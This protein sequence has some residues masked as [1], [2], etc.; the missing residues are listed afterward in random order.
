MYLCTLKI[1]IKS[2]EKSEAEAI[3]GLVCDTQSPEDCSY[4]IT[5]ADFSDSCEAGTD[6]AVIIDRDLEQLRSYRRQGEERVVFLA[7]AGEIAQLDDT[8]LSATDDLWVFPDREI[9]AKMLKVYFSKLLNTLKDSFDNR[10]QDICFH[11]FI[12]SLPDLVW[13]KDNDG[14]HLIVNDTFCGVVEKN[15][16]Q[17]YKRHHN[18]IWGLPE[19][20]YEHGEGICR[21]SEEVVERERKTCQFDEQVTTKDGTRQLVTYK[22]P[23]I[24]TD[25]KI[26][27]TCG[28]GHD[29]TDL[30]NVSKELKFIIDCIPFG[31]AI[32]DSE[33]KVLS[34]NRFLRKYF[35]DTEESKGHLFQEWCDKLPKE[36]LGDNDCEEEYRIHLGKKEHILRFREEP[37]VDI[38]GGNLGTLHFIRDVTLQ[39]NYDQQNIKHANTDFLTGLNNRRSLFD[40]LTGLPENSKISII[41]ADLDRFKS[42][43]DT[44]G[45]AAGDEA[46]EITSRT[47]EECFE[48]GFIARLGGDEFL[49]ALVGEY[50]LPE[51]EK[52]TQTLLDTLLKKYSTKKEFHALSSS[53]GIAQERLA[54]CD[55][56]SIEN[57]IKRSDDALYTAKES[58]K[59]RYCVNK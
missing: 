48:D 45:H 8:T 53:A 22:S 33:D 16:Q 58:G 25:G 59:A 56:G 50:E 7:S 36:K 4:H 13:F 47:L 26:F 40:Y 12:D 15:K 23:L 41:M 14:A 28:M 20:D 3:A 55:I 27:G 54:V 44:Y 35:P 2:K 49:V 51:V 5:T 31:V 52:R 9:S 10:R 39:Y 18:Y 6:C 32:A 43:N 24:D 19:D 11:T 46:L 1:F 42:V 17:I 21:K 30:Q 37:I 38:F 34:V 29:T 57:L